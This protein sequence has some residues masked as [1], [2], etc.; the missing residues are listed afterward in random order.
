MPSQTRTPTTFTTTPNGGTVAWSNSSNAVTA[1]DN[2]AT[3]ATAASGIVTSEAILATGF[4]FSVPVTATNIQ[5]AFRF[6]RKASATPNVTSEPT[7]IEGGV[8]SNTIGA[9]GNWTTSY[10]YEERPA[11]DYGL[12]PA[13]VN[14]SD[15][16][17]AFQVVFSG[18]DGSTTVTAS[19]DA[20]EQTLTWDGDAAEA[21]D[22]TGKWANAVTAEST[23]GRYEVHATTG[24]YE[25]R[26]E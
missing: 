15:Y 24:R 8:I 6:R 3:V 1:D 14:A 19:L 7:T 10:A 20:I 17:V 23:T 9:G 2:P 12:T 13:I 11:A 25:L 4:G 16:G 22:M 18:G 21:D 5:A 26:G